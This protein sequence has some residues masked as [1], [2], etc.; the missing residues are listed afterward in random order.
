MKYPDTLPWRINT[1]GKADEIY[2]DRGAIADMWSNVG[3][4][5]SDN[6]SFEHAQYIVTAANL[7]PEFVEALDNLVKMLDAEG[8]AYRPKIEAAKKLLAKVKT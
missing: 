5:I 2:C 4:D 7:L 8:H 6:E 1:G 3:G